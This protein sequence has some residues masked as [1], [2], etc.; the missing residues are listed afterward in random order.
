M[1]IKASLGLILS[2]GAMAGCTSTMVYDLS[3][4]SER[5][6]FTQK[7]SGQIQLIDGTKIA[8]RDFRVGPDTLFFV[9]KPVRRYTRAVSQTA[10]KNGERTDAVALSEIAQVSAKKINAGKTAALVMGIPAAILGAAVIAVWIICADADP[11]CG[12]S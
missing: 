2:L 9:V 6:A 10:S 3:N 7:K 1:R 5:E 8:G 4:P 12:G 11:G